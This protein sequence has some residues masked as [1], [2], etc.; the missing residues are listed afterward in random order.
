MSRML[1]YFGTDGIRGVVGSELTAEFALRVGIAVGK[2]LRRSYRGR[3]LPYFRRLDRSLPHPSV[4]LAQDTRVS[5]PM[6]AQAVAGG[7]AAAGVTVLDL[8]IAPTPLVAL[9]ANRYNAIGGVMITAS[10]NPVDHNGIK[11]FRSDGLKIDTR[12]ASAVERLVDGGQAKTPPPFGTVMRIDALPMYVDYLCKLGRTNGSGAKVALDLAH[13]AACGVAEQAFNARGFKVVP[14]CAEPDGERINVRCGATDLRR[15]KRAVRQSG[16]DWGFAFD[17]D[18]DRVM[19]VDAQGQVVDG[20]HLLAFLGLHHRTY[21]NARR[22]VFTQVTNMGVERYLQDKGFHTYR[23][24][25]GDRN[26]L[27]AMR[28]HDVLI[29]GEQSGHIICWDRT[30]GGDGV[31]VALFVSELLV[32]H[33]ISL[34]EIAR[35]IPAYTQ[36]LKNVQMRDHKK[37]RRDDGFA[38]RLRRLQAGYGDDVRFYI[39]P[40]GTESLVRVLTE[41]TSPATARRANADVVG[42]FS[43][44]GRK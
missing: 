1:K 8:G 18:A 24:A 6:L 40:S 34:G 43:A 7:L 5:S 42:L 26:V 25:V 14:V 4:L 28:K 19:A 44:Y 16:A 36:V 11:V 13:G 32:R 41:S 38:R 33:G 29:G 20:D 15:L 3:K 17:G 22:L 12:T 23:T 35:Q 2:V 27:Q 39:R 10:H 37:W 30:C 21:R 9:M 31:L